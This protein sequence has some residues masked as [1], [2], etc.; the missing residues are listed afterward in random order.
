MAHQAVAVVVDADQL[1]HHVD[2]LLVDLLPHR[3]A[4]VGLVQDGD[5]LRQQ[6]RALQPDEG[7]G[8]AAGDRR[9]GVAQAPEQD[10]GVVPL[11]ADLEGVDGGLPDLLLGGEEG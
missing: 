9:P 3:Q 10:V 6:V 2:L 7:L 4:R 8:G 11:A 5:E 1:A